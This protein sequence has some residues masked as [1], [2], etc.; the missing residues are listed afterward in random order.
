MKISSQLDT[1][2]SNN[3]SILPSRHWRLQKT[4]S[5]LCL[6]TSFDHEQFHQLNKIKVPERFLAPDFSYEADTSRDI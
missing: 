1:E 3:D 4:F 2:L 5:G 6:N